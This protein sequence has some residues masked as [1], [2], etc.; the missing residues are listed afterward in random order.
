[1]NKPISK[2]TSIICSFFCGIVLSTAFAAPIPDIQSAHEVVDHV[3]WKNIPIRVV[4]PVGQ[5][6]RI[7]F[8]VPVKIEWPNDVAQKTG[9]LQLRENGSVYWTAGE[10]FDR[11]RVNVFTFTGESY[12]LDVEARHDAPARTLV[13][14]DDRFDTGKRNTTKEHHTKSAPANLDS[15][16]LVR[17]VSQMLYAPRRLIKQL[18]GV[19]RVPVTKEDVPLFKGGE[20]RTSPI[21]QWKTPGVPALYVTAIR[22]TSNALIPVM[23]D[24]RHLRGD[25]LNATP[26]HGEVNAAGEDG[27]TTAW[28]LVSS[29]PFEETVQ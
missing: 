29:R 25:W 20:L 6:R 24:P 18:P 7:D 16:D 13:I 28:Y 15:V 23:L 21:A 26:Q 12:L 10:T 19:T 4:L 2:L 3:V 17:F 22:V 11:Q 1:M 8:P 14:L 5:E 27:D 9:N